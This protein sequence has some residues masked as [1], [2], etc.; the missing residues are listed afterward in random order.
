MTAVLLAD[1]AAPSDHSVDEAP[2][3]KDPGSAV[4]GA[5]GAPSYLIPNW[6]LG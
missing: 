5:A 4:G 2:V 6:S 3:Q 1:G